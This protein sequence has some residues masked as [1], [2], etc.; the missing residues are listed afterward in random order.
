MI[1]KKIYEETTRYFL[2][3]IRGLLDDASVSEILINGPKQIYYERAGRL[4]LSDCQFQDEMSL[5]AAVRNIA[6]FVNR[7]VD[8][9]NHSMDARLPNG[10]RVHVII[11]PC[12]RQG[13]CLSIRKFIKST[14]SLEK[15]VERGSMTAEAAEFLELIVLL[16]KNTVVAGGTGT[17]KTSL[18]NA[19]STKIP[20][21][22]RI[23]VIEDS[24]ELQLFQPH[25]VYLEAQPARA[26]GRGAVSIRDLF[27]DSLRMRPDRIVVG[28]IRRGEA[29]DLIQSM[30]SGH[31]G[32]LTTVHATTALDAAIRLETLSLMAGIDI[33]IYVAR[34]QV[35]SALDVVVNIRRF[36]DG[37]RRL[38]SISQCLGLKPDNSYHVEDIYRLKY[39]PGGDAIGTMR[40][41]GFI[42]TFSPEVYEMGFEDK[43]NLC[44]P[45]FPEPKWD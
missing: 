18:L 43:V 38:Y 44:K 27:V 34:T 14:F 4:H 39:E 32:S 36:K 3:P 22:E 45:L 16:H 10:S 35:A 23:V 12:S 37:S 42:P 17:G 24:A 28:E 19:L 20:E 11:A 7:R 41:T 13:P 31:A 1:E 8:S 26:D 6:E 15:L 40:P 2:T 33:P 30:I 21:H 9:D 25:T 5:M 29:L